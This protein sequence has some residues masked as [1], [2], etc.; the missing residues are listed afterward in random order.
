MNPNFI[1]I[2]TSKAGSTWIYNLLDKHPDVFMA[3]GKGAYYFDSHYENGIK[4]YLNHFRD[5]TERVRGEVSHSY[6]F[7][8][9]ACQRIHQFNPEIRLMACLRNPVERA[10]S[11]YL[12]RVKNGRLHGSFEDALATEPSLLDR[13]RYAAHLQQYLD[14]FDR[15][16]LH[17]VD[18]EGIQS[19]PEKFARELFKFLDVDSSAD[20]YLDL[21]RR[22]PA[23]KPRS[24]WLAS[25]AKKVAKCG[26]KM[27]LRKL[28][29]TAKTSVV[30]RNLL[31]RPF[32]DQDKPRIKDSTRR[33][34][35]SKFQP[36]IERLD[37]MLGTEFASQWLANPTTRGST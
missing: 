3:P 13:G 25:A 20:K 37:Q 18:F 7:S 26:K 23:G 2:G 6:L 32:T 30:L 17:I 22:M 27:G 15:A 14:T 1:Y 4:W 12:D 34:L 28:L 5:A 24:R 8:E 11:A 19:S 29:G 33:E 9:D 10:F 36:E 16:N 35:E 31:Y 21:R